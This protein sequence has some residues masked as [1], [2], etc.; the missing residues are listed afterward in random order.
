MTPNRSTVNGTK[1]F[2]W[3]GK[4]CGITLAIPLLAVA[5]GCLLHALGY[6]QLVEAVSARENTAYLLMVLG[7]IRMVWF[8]VGTT[9]RT[10]LWT[11]VAVVI[12]AGSF[13]PSGN[14][15]SLWGTAVR[16]GASLVS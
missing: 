1:P 11:P 16:W 13:I 6:P 7:L 12:A 2:T 3:L 10:S 5:V 15:L 9:V 8:L 14:G 4:F